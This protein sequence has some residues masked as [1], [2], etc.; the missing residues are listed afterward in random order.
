[1]YRSSGDFDRILSTVLLTINYKSVRRIR[2]ME[3]DNLPMKV[4][5]SNNA[6]DRNSS[7]T[8]N[9]TP[10]PD[11]DQSHQEDEPPSIRSDVEHPS[12]LPRMT[13]IADHAQPN[14]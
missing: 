7:N 8:S 3:F 13:P 12:V 10:G 11:P 2:A 5:L 14:E 1:M 4:P 6:S 9:H